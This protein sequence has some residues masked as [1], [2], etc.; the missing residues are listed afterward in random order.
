MG[1]LTS[2]DVNQIHE[3][4]LFEKSN[5]IHR[6]LYHR[7]QIDFAYNSNHIEGSRLSHDQTRYIFETNSIILESGQKNLMIDDIIETVNHFAC[8]DLI[9]ENATDKLTED[10]IKQLHYTLKRGTSYSRKPWFN[11]GDYKQLPNEV[12]G[13][14]TTSFGNCAKRNQT[15]I[16][17]IQSNKKCIIYNTVRFS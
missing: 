3:R 5:N 17:E 16:K 6:G 1:D 4:L 10:F 15:F 8:F 7:L 11:I 9:L 14:T 12:G 2:Y 13:N